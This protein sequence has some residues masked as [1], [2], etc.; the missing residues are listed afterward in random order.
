VTTNGL[1]AATSLSSFFIST[2][3]SS[4]QRVSNHKEIPVSGKLSTHDLMF[5]EHVYSPGGRKTDSRDYIQRSTRS[6]AVAE[7]P[8]MLRVCI[9]LIQNVKRSLLLLVVSASDNI[10]LRT[11]KFF[12]VVF[13]SAYWSM[14][15]AVINK[16]SM[17]RR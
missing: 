7:R 13:S 2:H 6:S 17:V 11:I 9:A 14:L 12:S 3:E 15:Q 5:Y 1:L 10:P 16:H 8:R 4:V